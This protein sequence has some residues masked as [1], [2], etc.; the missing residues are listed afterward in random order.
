MHSFVAPWGIAGGWALSLFAGR[1]LRQHGDVD[2]AI[3][4]AHQHRLR[5]DLK[6]DSAEHVVAGVVRPWPL[7]EWLRPPIH[8]VYVTWD[9]GNRL[10]VLLNDADLATGTWLYRRDTR[11]RRALDRSFVRAGSVPILSPEIVLLYKSK[12]PRPQDESDFAA[13]LPLLASDQCEWLRMALE[14][15]A[16]GHPWVDTI[17]REAHGPEHTES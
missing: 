8:E 13:V 9:D 7:G 14:T 17:A 6:P 12:A 4:R 5:I 10:E 2:V 15:T 11:V 3:L 16:P 1:P